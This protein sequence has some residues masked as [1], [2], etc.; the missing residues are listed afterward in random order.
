LSEAV[1]KHLRWKAPPPL[2][3]LHWTLAERF[4][5]TLDTID[6]LSFSRIHEFFQIEDGRARAAPKP[7]KKGQK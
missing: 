2:A 6:G 7:K 4:G 3:L 1:Y 5:W